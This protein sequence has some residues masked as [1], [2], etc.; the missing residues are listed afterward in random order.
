MSPVVQMMVLA[1]FYKLAAALVQPV[2]DKRITGCIRS[3][4]EGYA[5]MLRVLSTTVILFLITIAVIAAS[6]S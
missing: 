1:L 4:S 5:L 3:V 6:T 2:S